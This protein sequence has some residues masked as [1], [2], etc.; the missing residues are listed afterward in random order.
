MDTNAD[1][2]RTNLL[3]LVG[4]IIGILILRLLKGGD[5]LIQGSTLLHKQP[6]LDSGVPSLPGM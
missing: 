6:A 2:R 5:V 3:P 1:P 4:I